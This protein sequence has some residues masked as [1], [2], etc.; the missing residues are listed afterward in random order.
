MR[1]NALSLSYLDDVSTNTLNLTFVARLQT[2]AYD[3]IMFELEHSDN[4]T[5]HNR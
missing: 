1:V 3:G 5:Q 2:A 4:T